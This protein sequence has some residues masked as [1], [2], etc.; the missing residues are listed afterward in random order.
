[1]IPLK[2]SA[3]VKSVEPSGCGV[4]VASYDNRMWQR[5]NGEA[6]AGWGAPLGDVQG[7]ADRIADI[8][9]DPAAITRASRNAWTFSQ[10]HGFQ[11]EFRRRMEHLARIAG[12]ALPP[13]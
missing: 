13:V 4:A 6:K 3:I 2:T 12:I 10:A 9:R 8:A 5:L 7:L 1:M 11:P